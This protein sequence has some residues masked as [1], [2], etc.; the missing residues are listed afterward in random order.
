MHYEMPRTTHTHKSMLLR[1]VKFG[2]PAL[3]RADIE[4]TKGK[5]SR[6]GRSYGGAPLRGNHGNGRGRGGQINYGDTRP[7][8]F[9]AHINPGFPPQ[10]VPNA[11]RNGLPPPPVGNWGPPGVGPDAYQRG[12]PPPQAYG[13]PP[14]GYSHP[15][16]NNVN[17]NRISLPPAPPS[18][19]SSGFP[20]VNN[21]NRFSSYYAPPPNGRQSGQN[22]RYGR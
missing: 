4:A 13:I 5:A 10:G 12:P 20:N 3:D 17:Y 18:N 19:Q 11:Y 2:P 22:D 15:P 7:N 9:A 16:P 8:P 14:Y 21:E 6:S 1:G